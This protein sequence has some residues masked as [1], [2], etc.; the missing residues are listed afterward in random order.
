MQQKERKERRK[1]EREGERESREGG[2]EGRKF[3]KIPGVWFLHYARNRHTYF[4][5]IGQVL[6]SLQLILLP[7]FFTVYGNEKKWR[8]DE[9][10]RK[11]EER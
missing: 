11:R 2:I 5:C 3:K 4:N 6:S 10:F 9:K 7:W 1:K 8:G